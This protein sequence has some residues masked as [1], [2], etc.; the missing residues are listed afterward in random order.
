[1]GAWTALWGNSGLILEAQCSQVLARHVAEG[2]LALWRINGTQP[3]LDLLVCAWL[4]A[5]RRECVAVSYGNDQAEQG[6]NHEFSEQA[7]QRARFGA[8]FH[9][10]PGWP[11]GF[12]V[13]SFG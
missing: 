4:A 3:Y 5:A 12:I 11:A 1:M 10:T 8:V 6:G 2:L 9:S 7:H 13:D